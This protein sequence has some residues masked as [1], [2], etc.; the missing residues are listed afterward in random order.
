MVTV[1]HW[2]NVKDKYCLDFVPDI[3]GAVGSYPIA[4]MEMY[5]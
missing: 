5:S 4:T 3:L 2:R 1:R